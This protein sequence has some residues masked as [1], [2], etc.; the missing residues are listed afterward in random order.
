MQGV[1]HDI[2]ARSYRDRADARIN[3]QQSFIAAPITSGGNI[4]S[5]ALGL[6]AAG[7]KSYNSATNFGKTPFGSTG[8]DTATTTKKY[9]DPALQKMVSSP[10]R[11]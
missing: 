4:W 2:V 8:G 1:G 11:H 5:S 3:S 10:V 6:G 7:L 9:Y